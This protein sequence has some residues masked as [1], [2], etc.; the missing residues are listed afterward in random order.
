M[1]SLSTNSRTVSSIETCTSVKPGVWARRA[2]V[3]L[4]WSAQVT[5]GYTRS[6]WVFVAQA[7]VTGPHRSVKRFSGASQQHG[8]R[9]PDLCG[10][11]PAD[12]HPDGA[13][14]VGA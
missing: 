12:R 8:D 5:G 4:R 1:I 11:H 9:G 14:R 13:Y 2:M 3:D 6:I 10:V 7:N